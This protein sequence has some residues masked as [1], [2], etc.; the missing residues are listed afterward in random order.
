MDAGD[1]AAIVA[2]VASIA[3]LG[4]SIYSVRHTTKAA[5]RLEHVKWS[6]ERIADTVQSLMLEARTHADLIQLIG[7]FSEAAL[8]ASD[9][10]IDQDQH[11]MLVALKEDLLAIG[12]TNERLVELSLVARTR[13]AQAALHLQ[14]ALGEGFVAIHS[15]QRRVSPGHRKQSLGEPNWDEIDRKIER[16]VEDFHAAARAELGVE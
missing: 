10:R 13:L 16:A 11:Q 14:E 4:V 3:A 2:A 9:P 1:I 7:G 12:A 5:E 8:R 15:Y 6:R